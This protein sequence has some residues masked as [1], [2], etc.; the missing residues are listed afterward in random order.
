MYSDPKD[1]LARTKRKELIKTA[2]IV[3]LFVAGG[4]ITLNYVIGDPAEM[5]APSE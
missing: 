2:I 5:A 1:D 3:V 4:I